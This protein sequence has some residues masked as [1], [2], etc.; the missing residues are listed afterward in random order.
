MKT[1]IRMTTSRSRVPG[2]KNDLQFL[3]AGVLRYT[4]TWWALPARRHCLTVG[5]SAGA[6]PAVFPGERT[7]KARVHTLIRVRECAFQN[8]SWGRPENHWACRNQQLPHV[9]WMLIQCK[10][11][12][13]ALNCEREYDLVTLQMLQIC[14]W[15]L[16]QKEGANITFYHFL[17]FLLHILLQTL[18]FFSVNVTF[19]H[20]RTLKSL[21]EMFIMKKPCMDFIVFTKKK[22]SF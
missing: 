10:L 15:R 8:L 20:E 11:A 12:D 18:F 13:Y 14:L 21:W 19:M 1:P 22:K 6:A 7:H 3:R 4:M 9:S 16:F 2:L 17:D 5:T